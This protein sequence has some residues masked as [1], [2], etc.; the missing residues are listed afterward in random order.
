V[1]IGHTLN[2][3]D[4]DIKFKDIKTK[5]AKIGYKI[6]KDLVDSISNEDKIKFGLAGKALSNQGGITGQFTWVS[7]KYK[8][9]LGFKVKYLL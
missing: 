4:T 9:N 3:T 1:Y 7:P 6:G 2:L 5:T 8:D